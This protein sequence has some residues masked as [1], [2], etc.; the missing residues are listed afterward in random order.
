PGTL[1]GYPADDIDRRSYA[2]IICIGFE[3][4]AED[5]NGAAAQ[6]AKNRTKLGHNEAPLVM[7]N[8]HYS[9]E[10]LWMQPGFTSHMRQCANVLGKAA[11][12]VSE[13]CIQ[14]GSPDTPI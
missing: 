8:F 7:V 14:E 10:Q 4:Q 5:T 9:I 3:G 1:A 6:R 12:P 11:A 13:P 2:H